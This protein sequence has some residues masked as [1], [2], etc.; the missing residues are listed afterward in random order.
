MKI[1]L[2]DEDSVTERFSRKKYIGEIIINVVRLPRISNFS[3]FDVFN[4]FEDVCVNYVERPEEIQDPDIIILPGSKNTIEDMLYIRQTGIGERILEQHG[5]GKTIIGICAGYQML[6]ISIEDPFG[7]ESSI[8]EMEGLGILD[9]K[10]VMTREKTTDQVYGEIVSNTGI[11]EGLKGKMIKGY[12]IHM[13]ISSGI[14]PLDSFT[15][16][17][18][19]LNGTVNNNVIGTYIHGIFDSVEFTRGLLNN[20]RKNKG[21]APVENEKTFLDAKEKEFDKLAD[22]V[23]KNIDMKK[24]YNIV[25][26][27]VACC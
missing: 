9:I 17:G 6:G 19:G 27:N 18:N 23:R 13:G 25:Y 15:I 4:M 26:D 1:N 5:K 10:T 20:I 16:T 3:D 22:M 11:L 8:R 14:K 12:E 2:E 21:L 7:V 24:I